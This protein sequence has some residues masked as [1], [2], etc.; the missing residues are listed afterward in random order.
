MPV[1]GWN[2]KVL[3]RLGSWETGASE[4]NDEIWAQDDEGVIERIKNRES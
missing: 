3:G 4:C 2:L 1:G